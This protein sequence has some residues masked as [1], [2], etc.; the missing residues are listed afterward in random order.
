LPGAFL[1]FF[2]LFCLQQKTSN[3]DK[4]TAV[5]NLL[6]HNDNIDQ[7]NSIGK[8]HNTS[9]CPLHTQVASGADVLAINVDDGLI[10]GIP[11]MNH[12]VDLLE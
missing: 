5:F 1:I 4:T 2:A 3:V 6:A 9:S 7:N 8:K 11:A 10:I 12:F